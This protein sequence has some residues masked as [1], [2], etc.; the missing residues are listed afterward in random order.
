MCI[1]ICK[2]RKPFGGDSLHI[3]CNISEKP[4]QGYISP[5]IDFELSAALL[6][7][8]VNHFLI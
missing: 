8:G 6:K 4:P 1:N 5:I 3:K 7:S 2:S